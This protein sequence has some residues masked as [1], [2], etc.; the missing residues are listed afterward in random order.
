MSEAADRARR[1]S[2][3]DRR[4]AQGSP[5]LLPPP[6]LPVLPGRWQLLPSI[7]LTVGR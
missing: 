1:V 7:E 5:Q 4:A 2:G 6:V 3:P